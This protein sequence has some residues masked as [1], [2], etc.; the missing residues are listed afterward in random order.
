MKQEYELSDYHSPECKVFL[1][2]PSV[3]L[4]LSNEGATEDIGD[5]EELWGDTGL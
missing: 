3:V 5:L 4:C 2:M 1:T